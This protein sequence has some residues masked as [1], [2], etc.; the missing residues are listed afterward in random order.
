RAGFSADKKQKEFV[1]NRKQAELKALREQTHSDVGRP[2]YFWLSAPLTG[3]VLSWEF[4]ER[5]N[6]RTVNPSEPLLRIGDKSHGWEVELRI[7]HRHAGPILEA[8]GSVDSAEELDVDLLL[9]SA[10]TRT[11]RGKL[12]RSQVAAEASPDLESD[13]PEPVIRAI[14]RISGDDIL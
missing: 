13:N 8:L 14:V 5:Y 9:T 12:A 1:R 7:P 11:Y 4:R 10:P 2:G 6:N 3:S